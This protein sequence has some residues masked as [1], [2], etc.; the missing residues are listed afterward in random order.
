MSAVRLARVTDAPLDL[1]AHLDAVA[2]PRAGAVTT[3]LGRVRDH[4]P[5]AATRAQLADLTDRAEQG[6]AADLQGL[7]PAG[8]AQAE[9]DKGEGSTLAVP[10]GARR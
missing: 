6:V 8:A 9:P 4:D 1:A 3:F 10:V 7:L 5:D 2:D